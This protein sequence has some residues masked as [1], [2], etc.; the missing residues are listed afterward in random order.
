M[1]NS[2]TFLNVLGTSINDSS[3]ALIS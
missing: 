1:E 3:P 2:Q